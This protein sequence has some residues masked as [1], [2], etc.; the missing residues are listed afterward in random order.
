[1][2]AIRKQVVS[3]TGKPVSD[4]W[5]LDVASEENVSLRQ[6][7]AAG[8]AV[9]AGTV[10]IASVMDAATH[11]PSASNGFPEHSTVTHTFEPEPSQRAPGEPMSGSIVRNEAN[12]NDRLRLLDSA[13]DDALNDPAEWHDTV[14]RI[15]VAQARNKYSWHNSFLV[16][17]Q[18]RRADRR[19]DGQRHCTG[20]VA[21]KGQWEKAGYQLRPDAV[22]LHL[23]RPISVPIKQTDPTTGE[24]EVVDRYMVFRRSAPLSSV[25]DF[26]D[27]EPV[28]SNG[29]RPDGRPGAR[30]WRASQRIDESAAG[31]TA[32]ATAVAD[33]LTRYAQQ[34]GCQV[35]E[36]DWDLHTHPSR[37]YWDF[38]ADRVVLNSNLHPTERAGVL[39]QQLA[40]RADPHFQQRP[41]E[42]VFSGRH[43][44]GCEWVA[45][46]AAHAVLSFA[47]L[48]ASPEQ[49]QTTRYLTSWLPDKKRQAKSLVSR[50]GKVADRLIAAVDGRADTK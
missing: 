31:D 25:Y 43:R 12:L 1:M 28:G 40:H 45:E 4:S 48:H 35:V 17:S 5:I 23:V 15:A 19:S 10:D 36:E 18:N 39:A 46:S 9:A 41:P 3:R 29:T 13:L 8:S 50:V 16:T 20:D 22:P 30:T 7:A 27:L 34:Q 38:K 44:P 24:E 42:E 11:L 49:Q 26:C 2:D 32:A 33:R 37:G 47:G 21:S 14:R 6:P